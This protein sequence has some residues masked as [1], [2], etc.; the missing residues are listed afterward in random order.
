[1]GGAPRE[2]VLRIV[3]RL[4][5]ACELASRHIG[6]TA[7]IRRLPPGFHELRVVHITADGR[8]SAEITLQHPVVVTEPVAR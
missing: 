8:R 7:V 1:M 5:E 6:Y 4:D 3:A 2:Y